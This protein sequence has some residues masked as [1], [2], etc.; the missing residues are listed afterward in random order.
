MF[1]K[2]LFFPYAE[3]MNLFISTA[4]NTL[5]KLALCEGKREAANMEIEAPHAQAEKL[6]LLLE[7]LLNKSKITLKDITKIIVADE[8]EGFT[9]LRIGVTT[10][11][12][13]AYALNIPVI[14]EKGQARRKKGISAVAPCY[15]K[16][17]TIWK[18]A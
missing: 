9:A 15:N 14:S 18:K 13:L 5:I 7:K 6:L 3:S 10:A 4:S 12:A 8:G 2:K 1:A 17:P 11:N 16:P